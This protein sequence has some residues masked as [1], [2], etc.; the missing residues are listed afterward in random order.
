MKLSSW[1]TVSVVSKMPCK[2]N[3]REAAHSQA[4]HS[5]VTQ[6]S[7]TA[8]YVFTGSQEAVGGTGGGRH[9]MRGHQSEIQP[10]GIVSSEETCD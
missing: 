9:R 2:R 4:A 1:V 5:P 6:G 10:L 7:V 8:A 3:S